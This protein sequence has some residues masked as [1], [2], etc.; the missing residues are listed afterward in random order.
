MPFTAARADDWVIEHVTL[1][2][3]R[4]APQPDMT[5]AVEGDRIATVTPSAMAHGLKGRNIDAGI[6][7]RQPR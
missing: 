1:I 5:V 4:H 7:C 6:R 3:G 2:D